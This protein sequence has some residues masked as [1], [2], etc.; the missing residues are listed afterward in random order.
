MRRGGGHQRGNTKLG[1]RDVKEIIII[2][3][4]ETA[5]KQDETDKP[6]WS[7]KA[8]TAEEASFALFAKFQLDVGSRTEWKPRALVLG[9]KILYVKIAQSTPTC[10]DGTESYRPSQMAQCLSSKTD[11]VMIVFANLIIPVCVKRAYYCSVFPLS[12]NR[13]SNREGNKN[14]A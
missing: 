11:M 2:Y 4:E 6:D 5:A 10:E 12:K 9:S 14:M 7:D 3:I 13:N 8:R 1:R